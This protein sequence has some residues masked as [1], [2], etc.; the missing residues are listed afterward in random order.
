MPTFISLVK[1]TDQGIKNVR[2]SPNRFDKAREG[3]KK[4]GVELH[5][6]HFVS[7]H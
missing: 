7:R 2:D 6:C 3:F 4:N 1:W 5:F